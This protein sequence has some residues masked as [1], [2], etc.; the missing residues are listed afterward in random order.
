MES[1]LHLQKPFESF[2]NI[3]FLVMIKKKLGLKYRAPILLFTFTSSL[4]QKASQSTKRFINFPVS[5]SIN[6]SFHPIPHTKKK[7][8]RRRRQ[9]NKIK[10]MLKATNDDEKKRLKKFY[11]LKQQRREAHGK[12]TTNEVKKSIQ[13]EKWYNIPLRGRA[14]CVCVCVCEMVFFNKSTHAMKQSLNHCRNETR[15]LKR[16]RRGVKHTRSIPNNIFKKK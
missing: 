5:P 14:V 11:E 7:K 12:W 15:T 2:F 10:K 4:P 1:C 9:K 16:R 13:V 8:Q 6:I 3:S